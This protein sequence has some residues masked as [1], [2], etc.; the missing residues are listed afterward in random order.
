MRPSRILVG[1]AAPLVLGASLLAGGATDAQ[2]ACN[3]QSAGNKIKQ[4]VYIQFDNVHLRRDNPNV[5]SDLELMP[6]LLNFLT[7]NGVVSGNHHTPLISHTAT[8][9]ITAISG[10]YPDRMGI[11]V[12]NSFGFFRPNGTVGFTSSFAYWT[13]IGADGKPQMIGQDGKTAPAPWVS[14]TRAGCDVGAFGIANIEF[15]NVSTDIDNVFGPNSAEHA[16]AKANPAKAAADFEGI[17]IHCA[18]GSLLCGDPKANS[19]PDQLPDEPGGYNGFSAL[20]G[21]ANVQPIISPAG[22]IKDFDGNVIQDTHGN[23]GFPGF[24]P[25]ATQTLAYGAAMLEGGV[26]VVYLAIADLHDRNPNGGINHAF[27]PG[28]AEYVK[29]VKAYDVAFGKFFTELAAHGITAENT[30]FVVTADENDHFVGGPPSPANCDGVTVPCTYKNVGEIDADIDRLLLTERNNNTPFAIHF[31]DAPTFYIVGNPGQTD[32]LTRALEHDVSKLTAVNPI[33]GNTDQLTA[34]LADIAEQKLLHMKTASPAR[35]MTFT[36]FGNDD[37]FF[38]TVAKPAQCVKP[39]FTDCIF[40]ES[41]FAYNHGDFQQDITRSWLGMVGPGVKRLGRDDDVFSDHTDIRPT[42]MSLLGLKDDFI[43]DGRVLV[44]DIEPEALPHSLKAHH[45][46]FIDLA[47]AYKQLNAPVGS[48][49]LDSLVFATR[50]IE[51]D[52]EDYGEYLNIIG[53]ITAARDQ[54]ADEIKTVLDDAAFN[55]RPLDQVQ[56]LGLIARA[57]LI[58][59]EVAALA[60]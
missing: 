27:G 58:I 28:E 21:N 35:D 47:Q 2:A 45:D 10:L 48:V 32:P 30:L 40:E 9:Y 5:P 60:K 42:I 55:G 18:K 33:T 56:A 36:L 37:Y 22:A 59:A 17:V 1:A 52:D 3:L 19:K 8:D 20:F 14:Y 23:P 24:D 50:A 16:E 13:D 15:E 25:L 51:S 29:Q 34:R 43:H 53:Q 49:G 6:N 11:P 41:G 31:D 39:N 38:V 4:V 26:P 44:E 54:L 46:G 57:K 12:A 7:D